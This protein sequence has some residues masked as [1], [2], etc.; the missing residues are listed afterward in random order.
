M[1][2]SETPPDLLARRLDYIQKRW[3][4]L[5]ELSTTWGDEAIK[6]LLF[7]NAGAMAGSLSFIGA[8]A[9]IRHAAWPRVALMLFVAGVVLVG[10][11]H[12]LRYHRTE[13]LFRAWRQDTEKYNSD[14]LY[15]NDLLDRDEVR[16]KK[17]T[18]PLVLL[19][20]ASFGCFL[21]GLLIAGLNFQDITNA[22]PKEVV[23]ERTQTNTPNQSTA[24]HPRF[25][26]TTSSERRADTGPAHS[27]SKLASPREGSDA[28][29]KTT[30]PIEQKR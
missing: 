25:N 1:K 26:S 8:M 15:W 10:V 16:S 4:Q 11:Y 21:I 13:R 19:A 17:L 20:Y 2:R 5:S 29:T 30:G 28:S 24:A 9:H 7:V 18:W 6:Y 22:L 14:G 3:S 12:A 27:D 23:H